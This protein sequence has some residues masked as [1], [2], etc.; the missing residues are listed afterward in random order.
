MDNTRGDV[1]HVTD[2][3]YIE[4][5]KK[6]RINVKDTMEKCQLKS[7]HKHVKMTS[8]LPL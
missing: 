6:Q 5:S 1:S 8:E 7:K 3:V 4:K 2:C